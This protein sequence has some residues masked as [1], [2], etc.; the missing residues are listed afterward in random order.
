MKLSLAIALGLV[1]PLAACR[2]PAVERSV[3]TTTAAAVSSSAPALELAP[4]ARQPGGCDT[5]TDV[6]SP[7]TLR[8]ARADGSVVLYAN[9]QVGLAVV[10]VRDPDQ[11]K[12]VG[13]VELVGEPAGVFEV[14]GLGV[15]VY[16]PA[17]R[18]G[19]TAVRAVDIGSVVRTVGELSFVGHVR[20]ARRVGDFLV[21]TRD[22]PD[23]RTAVTSLAI[24]ERGITLR[25]EVVLGGA[26]S[27]TGASPRG[28][29]VARAAAK[30][31]G[32]DRTSVT[33]LGMDA[34]LGMFSVRGSTTFSG[35]IPR[36]RSSR[37][38]LD[39]TED[40][41]ARFVT[42]ATSACDFSAPAAYASIDFST[43]NEPRLTAWNLVAGAGDG[44]I[45]FQGTRLVVARPS[46][47]RSDASEVAFYRTEKDLVPAGRVRVRGSVGTVAVRDSGDIV[48]VGWTGSASA[49]KRAILHHIDA[50]GEPR[51]VGAATFGGD[52]TWTRAYDDDRVIG[53]DPQS[54]LAALPMTTVRGDLGPTS[55]AQVLSLDTTG[56][57]AIAEETVSL[58]DRLLFVKGRLLAF[59]PDG[60]VVLRRE[61]EPGSELRWDP[62]RSR[63]R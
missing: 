21:I 34:D 44:V 47:D 24:T 60:V 49:G 51:L 53:F 29:V 31:A 3:T 17:D 58:A 10:D 42:C 27:V 45:G 22:T 5:L 56:T 37:R 48:T 46:E 39:V 28:L 41:R 32:P 2:Q 36:W 35:V 40:D 12:M 50:R 19:I 43:P 33:W 62:L 1:F 7:D 57:H 25:D 30:D 14:R 11:P 9:E 8:L 15:V 55:A 63:G 13:L 6:E 61:S 54:M 52:W 59:S 4:S 16:S 23:G 26:G 38:V 18:A 20:D